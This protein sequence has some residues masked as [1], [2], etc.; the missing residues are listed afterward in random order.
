MVTEHKRRYAKVY[1]KK[2]YDIPWNRTFHT[3]KQRCKINP[4]YVSRGIKCLITCEEIKELWFRDKGWLLERPSIDRINNDGNYTFDNCRF[5][6][7]SENIKRSIKE[8]PWRCRPVAKCDD[9]GKIVETFSSFKETS[10]QTGICYGT[11]ENAIR[12]GCK[13]HGYYWKKLEKEGYRLV[14]RV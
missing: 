3:I 14:K 5:I 10:K 9:N 7:L 11:I 12:M 4:K 8:R 6:E 1:M 13:S 2:Y